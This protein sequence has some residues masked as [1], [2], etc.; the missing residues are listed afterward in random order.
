MKFGKLTKVTS[1]IVLGAVA[2]KS[3]LT[4]KKP[5]SGKIALARTAVEAANAKFREAVRLGKAADI[6]ALYADNASV[7]PP[8]QDVVRG[9]D[10]IEAYWRSGLEGGVKDAVLN[11]VD[12]DVSGDAIYEIGTYS[13]KIWPEGKTAWEDNGKYVVIW[14][15]AAEGAVKIEVDIW[16]SSLPLHQK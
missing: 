4:G 9:H 15:K 14:R 7:L 6:A 3:L 16:N 13:L 1:F 12:I 10:N 8:N 11:T 2:A 5:G